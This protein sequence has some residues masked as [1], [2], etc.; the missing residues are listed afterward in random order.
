LK[1]ERFARPSQERGGGG[2]RVTSGEKK[3]LEKCKDQKRQKKGVGQHEAGKEREVL[4]IKESVHTR[5]EGEKSVGRG[6]GEAW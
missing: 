1:R 2:G 4:G 5:S 3:L 6:I